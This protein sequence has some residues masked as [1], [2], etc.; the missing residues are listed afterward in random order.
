MADNEK[1]KVAQSQPV[2]V[3]AAGVN[4]VAQ[5]T[6]WVV[7]SFGVELDGRQTASIM[8]LISAVIALVVAIVTKGKVYPKAVMDSLSA[9]AVEPPPEI[10]EP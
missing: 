1:L 2:M 5:A 9:N 6:L 3:Y 8:F 4:I 7:L 10:G